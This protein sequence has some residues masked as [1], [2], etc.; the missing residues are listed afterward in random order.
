MAPRQALIRDRYIL[1]Q[2]KNT[3][4][5]HIYKQYYG[6]QIFLL[7]FEKLYLNKYSLLYITK[8][9]ENQRQDNRINGT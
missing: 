5:K 8:E 3:I 9:K 6:Y 2:E 7:L 4:L 1:K